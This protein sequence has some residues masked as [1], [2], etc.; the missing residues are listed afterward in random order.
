MQQS[1]DHNHCLWVLMTRV[2]NRN[3]HALTHALTAA[4][5]NAI[6]SPISNIP[7]LFTWPTLAT[8]AWFW[9]AACGPLPLPFTGIVVSLQHSSSVLLITRKVVFLNLYY[10][11]DR[12]KDG[13]CVSDIHIYVHICT[14]T[15][16]HTCMC[17]CE[18]FFF[19]YFFFSFLT[20]FLP[21]FFS[22]S[23]FVRECVCLYQHTLF[24]IMAVDPIMYH[25]RYQYN[26]LLLLWIHSLW[27]KS[28]TKP[29]HNNAFLI[30]LATEGN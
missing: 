28:Q 13:Q 12:W 21:F 16:T 11:V 4:T 23:F 7:E 9:G 10:E 26:F 30:A 18:Y 19:R 24:Q 15:H 27:S 1:T 3:T 20:F 5:R 22:S 29:V 2:Y 8:R 6:K 14:N 17:V 25:I